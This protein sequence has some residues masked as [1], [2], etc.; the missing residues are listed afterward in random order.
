MPKFVD[1]ANCDYDALVEHYNDVVAGVVH[2]HASDVERFRA[3]L[4][5]NTDR[6]AAQTLVVSE[7][8]FA[9]VA[10][11]QDKHR[12]PGSRGAL[13][14]LAFSPEHYREGFELLRSAE[15]WAREN[16]APRMGAFFQ[17]DTYDF[18][19]SPSACL[20]DRIG[21]IQAVLQMKGYSVK[22][23]EVFLDA[24]H[25][26]ASRPGELASQ[27]SESIEQKATMCAHPSFS[28]RITEGDKSTG[29]CDVVSRES[30]GGYSA[31]SDT[32]FYQWV[33]VEDA[34]QRRGLGRYL[35]RR[36]L[37]IGKESGYRHASISTALENHRAFVLYATEGFHVVDWTYGWEM[38]L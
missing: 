1:V 25:F 37:E 21:H 34:Y 15:N 36:A 19:H 8:G 16:G 13:R 9:H 14:F 17:N 2:C 31:E 30:F 4:S 26:T 7:H 28:I 33:G 27:F 29:R 20:S 18:Y 22:R 11:R 35:V 24:D 23:G 6:Y 38:P 12:R 32:L 10:V 5:R 3:E